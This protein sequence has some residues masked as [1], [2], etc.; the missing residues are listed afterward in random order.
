M[1]YEDMKFTNDDKEKL[2]ENKRMIIDWIKENI[3]PNMEKGSKIK[4]DF[5]GIYRCPRT[6][7]TVELYHFW[8][9]SEPKEFYSGGGTTTKGTIGYGQKFGYISQSFESVSSPYDI[10]PIVDNWSIIKNVLLN[11]IKNQKIIKNSIYNFS[12]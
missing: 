5:G 12:V 7:S 6:N 1:N 10:Y 4:C 11:E 3:I 8:V 9:Y 2:K